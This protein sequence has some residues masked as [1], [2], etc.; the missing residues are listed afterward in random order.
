MAA[1]HVNLV[2]IEEGRATG[3]ALDLMEAAPIRRYRTFMEGNDDIASIAGSDIVVLAAGEIRRPGQDRTAHFEDNKIIIEQNCAAI[4]EHCPGAIVVVATEPVDAMV[5]LVVHCTG[6]PRERV[7]GIGGILDSTRMAS[8]VAER[9]D[10]SPRDVNAL[11]IGSHTQKMVPLRHYTRVSGIELSTLMD[12]V[13]LGKVIVDTREAGSVIVDLAKQS[14]AFYAPS[15]AI[16]QVVE[17]VAID[18]KKILPLSVL[19][20]GEYGME[21]VAL[22]VP[23]KVGISGIEQIIELDLNEETRLAFQVSAEPIRDLV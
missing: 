7:M 12:E 22:S 3:K 20:Q 4:V 14:S 9:L 11:V 13:S 16:A 1:A 18:T 2:D 17:A 8:F 23:C 21:D 6:S 15:S 10:I 19:L 5:K